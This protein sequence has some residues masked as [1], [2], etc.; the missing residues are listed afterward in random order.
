MG[1]SGQLH[2]PDAVPSGG[3]KKPP[4]TTA[5]QAGWAADAGLD[6]E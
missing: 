4:L 1:V 5:Q 6:A 3:K 2:A